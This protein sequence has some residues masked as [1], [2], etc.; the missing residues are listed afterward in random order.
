MLLVDEDGRIA[1]TRVTESVQIR[2]FRAIP[3]LMQEGVRQ[4]DTSGDQDV[5]EFIRSRA[6][7]FAKPRGGLR[8]LG[9]DDRDFMTQLLVHSVDEFELPPGDVPFERRMGQTEVSCI[10]CHDRPGIYSIRSYV[11][12]DFPRGQYDLPVLQENE[13][14][15]GQGE[16]SAML[17]RQQ[18]SWGLLQG[19][20]EERPSQ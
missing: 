1:T 12:G 20:W 17:K 6:L 15:D 14:T 19:L 4:R 18:Y 2:V 7:L 13:N 11:G 8:P 9:P 5:Y 3:K 10:G 16:L